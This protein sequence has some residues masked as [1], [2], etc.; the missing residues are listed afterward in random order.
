M[1][2]KT[3]PVSILVVVVLLVWLL[4]DPVKR[5]LAPVE[6]VPR[7]VTA[8]GELAADELNTIDIFR[9]NSPS[10]VYV[11][12]ITLRRSIFSFNAV[13]IPQGTGSGFLWDSKG[14]IVTNYHVISDAS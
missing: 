10:V 4:I 12:S 6:V 3:S 9:E 14:R 2:I 7:A 13:E 5:F 11:T 8:R 1:N